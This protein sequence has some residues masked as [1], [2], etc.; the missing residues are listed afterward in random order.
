[1]F[2]AT[3]VYDGSDS[4][5]CIALDVG[6][7]LTD[8]HELDHYWFIGYNERTQQTGAFPKACVASLQ[9]DADPLPGKGGAIILFVVQCPH[10]Y[11]PVMNGRDFIKKKRKKR[12]TIGNS[13]RNNKQ[14]NKR[15]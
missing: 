9:N 8:V 4:D 1:M 10:F 13:K 11:V 3:N 14:Y 12:N 7:K 6:D 15:N 2:H 5:T